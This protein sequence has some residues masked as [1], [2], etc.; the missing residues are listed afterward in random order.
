M[1]QKNEMELKY[2]KSEQNACDI[3]TKNVDELT[4]TKHVENIQNGNIMFFVGECEP[5]G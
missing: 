3:L 2:V 5:D 1:V 4:F